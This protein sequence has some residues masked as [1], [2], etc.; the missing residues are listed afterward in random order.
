MPDLSIGG[1]SF[2]DAAEDLANDLIRSLVIDVALEIES[3]FV[4]DLNSMFNPY[5]V[6]R[7]PDFYIEISRFNMQA[8]LG[9]NEWTSQFDW[10]GLEFTISQAVSWC[11]IKIVSNRLTLSLTCCFRSCRRRCSRLVL[12]CH[13]SPSE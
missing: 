11:F 2:T 8:A 7:M 4:V 5:A 1:F 6:N 9:V 10:N 3:A 13:H 12:H